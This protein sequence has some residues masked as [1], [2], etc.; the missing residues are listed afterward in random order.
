[1]KKAVKLFWLVLGFLCLGLGTAGVVLP[2]LPTVPFYMATAFC[3]AKSAERL[4]KWFTGTRSYKKYLEGFVK[5]NEMAWK[6]KL[7]V[8]ASVTAVM[9]VGFIL[10]KH[11]P[12]A[13]IFLLVV[14]VCH[15]LFLFLWVKTRKPKNENK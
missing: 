14:W 4:H 3:F 13:R 11:V 10:M 1:M 6:T 2:L 8:L 15:F 9:A 12:A 5:H 7:S